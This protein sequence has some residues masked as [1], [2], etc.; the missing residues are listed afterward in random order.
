MTTEEITEKIYKDVKPLRLKGVLKK[1]KETLKD[2]LIKFFT[3]WNNKKDTIY[4]GNR[5]V[6]TSP[7]KR[8]SLGD[9]F[10]ICRYYYPK[11]TLE[12][13]K[14]IVYNEL[15]E[16]IPR[17][18]SSWCTR[19]NKRVFYQGEEGQTTHIYDTSK[20]DEFGLTPATW[21]KL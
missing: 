21:R 8:R 12:E 10:V 20:H 1:R 17:F 9:I 11:C 13:V 15:F 3:E 19:V 4:V 2:F 18:R 7:G 6:Q 5:H 14:S 16:E